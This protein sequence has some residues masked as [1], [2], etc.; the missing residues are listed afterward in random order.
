MVMDIL[1]PSLEDLLN[2]CSRKFTLKTV[3]F[4][5]HELL[6]RIEYIHERGFIHRDIKP[7]NFLI[8][9]K[10][11]ANQ[12]YVIDFGLAKQYRDPQTHSH[13]PLVEYKSLTGTARYASVN[14][15]LGFE[16]SRRDD[17]ESLG[18]MLIYFI[19]G[20]P[21]QKLKA[22]TKEELSYKILTKKM[23]TTVDKLC[24]HTP[25][26]FKKYF[27]YCRNLQFEAQPDYTYLKQ[28]F[29]SSFCRLN[30]STDFV[31]DWT[32]LNLQG[33]RTLRRSY[34]KIKEYDQYVINSQP[35]LCWRKG[36]VGY[37]NSHQY[38][39]LYSPRMHF[40]MSNLAH[41]MNHVL[42]NSY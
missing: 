12:V 6:T 22:F 40:D 23:Q 1:G 24:Y 8:G 3:L 42:V 18:F 21:W 11:K 38:S 5:A 35:Q 7:E 4:L 20:L 16:V 30:Y 31:F 19:R 26:E 33:M 13:I 41:Y 32:V 15:H 37:G 39:I 17:L 14:A 9:R 28:M 36:S 34:E 10:N 2:F 29:R 27:M 25:G